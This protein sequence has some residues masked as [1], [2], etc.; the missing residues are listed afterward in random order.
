VTPVREVDDRKIGEGK[1]GP[2]TK[3]IQKLFFDI[4]KGKVKKYREWLE[5]V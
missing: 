5:K 3:K 1:P 2:V 4:V